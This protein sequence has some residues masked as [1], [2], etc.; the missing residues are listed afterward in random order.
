MRN[1]SYFG[2]LKISAS[3]L[4]RVFSSSKGPQYPCQECKHPFSD[5]AARIRHRKR[6]HGYVPYHTREYLVRQA[7]NRKER[8]AEGAN[9]AVSNKSRR[10]CVAR[11]APDGL[12][13]ASSSAPLPLN[14]PEVAYH[15]NYWKVLVNFAQS[16]ALES[17]HPRD[18]PLTLPFTTMPGYDTP[19][20]IQPFSMQPEA[21]PS[22][23]PSD[24]NTIDYSN[25]LA[26]MPGY[27]AIQPSSMQPE[28]QPS[29]TPPEFNTIDYSDFLATMPGYDAIQ[30]S[31]MQPETQPSPTPSEFNTIDY[32]DFLA[33]MPGYDVIQPSP[34]QPD[35]QP[36]PTTSEFNA[37]DYSCFLATM[38]A[39]QPSSMQPEEQPQPSL[40]PLDFT[41]DYSDPLG[42]QM[43]AST[44]SQG[45]AF[46]E[47]FTADHCMPPYNGLWN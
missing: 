21:Q 13:S 41:L 20:A 7:L 27:D 6:A 18:V 35:I 1:S 3:P 19:N 8:V 2:F 34:I 43:D 42:P 23:T 10:Q 9:K 37:I 47:L 4:S 24:F 46:G 15:D 12:P 33:T 40:I 36:S 39:I 14:V 45:Q 44:L 28:T 32:S 25:F 29:P 38:P 5:A 26:T 30:P 17:Q 31:S 16:C 11:A 22:L